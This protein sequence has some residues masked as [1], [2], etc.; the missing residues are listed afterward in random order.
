MV[1]FSGGVSQLLPFRLWTDITVGKEDADFFF[2]FKNLINKTKPKK[3]F[4]HYFYAR[5][6]GTPVLILALG[7][8]MAVSL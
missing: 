1:A 7:R 5:C 3:F 6:G 8:Q 2:P 4:F